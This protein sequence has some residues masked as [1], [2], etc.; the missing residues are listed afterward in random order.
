MG[1]YR[2]IAYSCIPSDLAWR[3]KVDAMTLFVGFEP[4][5]CEIELFRNSCVSPSDLK[6]CRVTDA[7]ASYM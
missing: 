4:D 5:S 6:L 3:P 7:A 1:V 2:L